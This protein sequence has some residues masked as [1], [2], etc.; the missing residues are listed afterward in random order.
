M[1]EAVNLR[2]A[3]PTQF[4][5]AGNRELPTGHAATADPNENEKLAEIDK[6]DAKNIHSLANCPASG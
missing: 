2:H 1:P 3:G 5:F 6:F 4:D